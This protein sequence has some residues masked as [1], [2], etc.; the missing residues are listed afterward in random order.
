MNTS[1]NDL[2]QS[3]LKLFPELCN[4]DI[5]FETFE[6]RPGFSTGEVR[7]RGNTFV[8]RLA[9]RVVSEFMSGLN[10]IDSQN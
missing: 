10:S 1:F 8:V 9:A 2:F 4:Y 5:A 6:S 7:R 3:I